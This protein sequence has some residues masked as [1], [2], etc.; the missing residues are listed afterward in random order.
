MPH[1]ATLTQLRYLDLA[2]TRVTDKGLRF[3][4]QMDNLEQ[5]SLAFGHFTDR[6]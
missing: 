3:L 2:G 1:L 5:F 6:T 4:T